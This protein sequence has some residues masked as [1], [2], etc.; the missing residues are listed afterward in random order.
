MAQQSLKFTS[1]RREAPAKGER[2][3]LSF[4]LDDETF[5]VEIKG[6]DSDFLFSWSEMADAAD[7]QD[8]DS[9]AG[10]AFLAR[11]F[12]LVMGDAEYRRFRQHMRQHHTHPDTVMEIMQGIN[13][14]YEDTVEEITDRPTVP[15]APSSH[16]RGATDERTLRIMSLARAGDVH[17]APPPPAEVQHP[18]ARDEE[19]AALQ[20]TVAEL[21]AQRRART[22]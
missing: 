2:R 13:A 15:S 7:S 21:N 20:A 5:H 19:E 12:R 8:L 17:V 3:G 10:A 9:P 22:G 1:K 4:E 18:S 14:E 6:D 11:F 16:G